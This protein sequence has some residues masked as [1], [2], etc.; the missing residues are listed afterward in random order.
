MQLRKSPSTIAN[1][2]A[3]LEDR[4]QVCKLRCGFAKRGANSEIAVQIWKSPSRFG[5]R[6]INL[7]TAMQICKLRCGFGNRSARLERWC[8]SS[9]GKVSSPSSAPIH[10]SR[11][12]HSSLIDHRL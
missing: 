1:A 12:C 2:R 10:L 4:V 5:K 3:N 11:N 7:E 9:G 8:L 6:D